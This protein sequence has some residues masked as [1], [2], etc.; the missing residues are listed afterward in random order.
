MKVDP[1][2]IVGKRFGLLQVSAYRG[3]TAGGQHEYTCKC[4]CG[5]EK[6]TRRNYLFSGTTTSCGCYRKS[7]CWQNRSSHRETIRNAYGR[8]NSPEYAAWASMKDRCFNSN[9]RAYH[10]YGGRGIKV[11]DEW[12]NSFE[13]F[14][15]DVGRRPSARHSLER[16]DNEIGYLSSNV[17]W[18][19]QAD[20]D[21]NKRTNRIIEFGGETRTLTQWATLQGM[22]KETLHSRLK[23]GWG[24]EKALTTPPR[25]TATRAVLGRLFDKIEC[26]EIRNMAERGLSRSEIARRLGVTTTTISR[27]VDKLGAYIE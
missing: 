21:N 17:V 15:Q 4:D 6:V 27:V 10:N 3:K 1:T 5:S 26:I 14:L 22:S 25:G 2:D 23:A 24:V 20:Q 9:H 8:V 13:T 7:V 11:C 12:V 16:V 18:A 19:T